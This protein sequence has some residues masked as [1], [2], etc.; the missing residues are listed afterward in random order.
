MKQFLVIKNSDKDKDYT[1]T[2]QIQQT[3]TDAGGTVV[4]LERSLEEMA[5]PIAL[6]EE[7]DCVI[8]LGGDG[9]ILRTQRAL[10]PK[11]VPLVGVNLGNLGFLTQ[12]EPKNLNRFLHCLLED[13]VVC[14]HRMMLKGTMYHEGVQVYEDIALNDIVV[15]RS[16]LSRIIRMRAEVNGELLNVYDADGIVVATPTG[17]TA[18]N[19]S[20]GGPVVCPKTNLMVVTPISPHSLSAR[21]VILSEN[22]VIRITIEKVRVAKEAAAATFDGQTGIKMVPGDYLEI[23]RLPVCASLIKVQNMSFYEVLRNKMK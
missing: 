9:S 14:E 19:L 17:S 2:K 12:T 20:A 5:E 11:I 1:L 13:E 15:G 6:S 21:S 22:D 7:V 16:G 10:Y 18:Y 4:V 8:V 3:V 23:R